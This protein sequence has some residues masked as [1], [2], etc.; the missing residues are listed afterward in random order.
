[1][2]RVNASPKEISTHLAAVGED[3]L[4]HDAGRATRVLR[5]VLALERQ[6]LHIPAVHAPLQV[7]HLRCG[8]GGYVAEGSS[9]GSQW[10]LIIINRPGSW[11]VGTAGT[12]HSV[13]GSG[14]WQGR[15]SVMHADCHAVAERTG[16]QG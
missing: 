7:G 9:A 14:S 13:A 8:G 16:L 1:M 10:G 11:L 12:D 2:V 3:L 6:P 15:T 5:V 4:L